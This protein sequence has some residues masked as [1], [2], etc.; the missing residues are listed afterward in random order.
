M[1][2]FSSDARVAE[3]EMRAILFVLVAFAYIDGNVDASERE[4]IRDTVDNLVVQRARESFAGHPAGQDAVVP[5]WKAHFYQ[6][7]DGMEHDI[8]V[9][10]T[11]SVSF[12]ES[13]IQFVHARLKLRCFELLDKL[14]AQ[15]RTAMLEL[16]DQ[17]MMADGVIHPAEQAFRDELRALLEEEPTR[18]ALKDPAARPAA[19]V[20]EDVRHLPP[21]RADHP[22]FSSFEHPYVRDRAAFARQAAG[23]ME[24]IRRFEAQIGQARAKGQG[25]LGSAMHTSDL[26]GQEPFLDGWVHVYP[27]APGTAYEITVLGDLHGCYACLKAALL[28]SDF[29]A[30]VEAYQAKPEENP[31][32]L[33]VFLG[34]YID[35][36][37][38]SYDGILRTALR[39]YLAVPPHVF[40]LRGNHEH[41]IGRDGRIV[42]PV[43]PAEAIESIASMAPPGL[44]EAHLR[45]FD[46][47]PSMLIFDRLLFVH[48]GIPREDTF[49]T[50]LK[51]LAS[52]NDP[53]IRLQMA[54]SDPSDADFVPLEL[55]RSNTRFPFGRLQFRAFMARLGCTILVRGHER[56]VE[57]LRNVYPDPDLLLLSLFS[58]GGAT[59]EDLPLDSNYREVAPKAL[60]IHYEDG[61]Y[62]VMPFPI[63]YERYND[64]AYNGFL[65]A[66][67]GAKA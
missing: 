59:N 54:W 51:G 50:K 58:A 12:G 8:R 34:D 28:Q 53:E 22:F 25:R 35:R 10:F 38:Y 14:D 49:N 26:A 13:A 48:A 20:L 65:R 56:V 46:Q 42:S 21:K 30:K 61:K 44:L 32:P 67:G 11:E 6:A 15:N 4:F 60:R 55:Q 45:L 41:Y 17:L 19:A 18:V 31:F 24:I 66:R 27:P 39:L 37:H 9:D 40:V 7:V 33:L 43:R 29:F 62:R 2:V 36:G 63:A 57:G 5:R 3:V 64:P 52:L 1:V 23:D 47:L 16:V